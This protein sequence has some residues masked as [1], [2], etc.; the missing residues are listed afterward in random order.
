M[1]LCHSPKGT[2][3]LKILAIFHQLFLQEIICFV[4]WFA[5]IQF[6]TKSLLHLGLIL[7]TTD[8]IH[9]TFVGSE[10]FLTDK[11]EDNLLS[12]RA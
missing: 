5:K 8:I 9:N 7:I 1:K 10:M 2:P 6:I 4:N 11:L 12:T 3:L